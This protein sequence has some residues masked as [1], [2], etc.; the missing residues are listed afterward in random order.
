MNDFTTT[1]VSPSPSSQRSRPGGAI[2]RAACGLGLAA[3]GFFGY[4]LLVDVPWIRS[5]GI[6]NA[7]LLILG[8]VVSWSALWRRPRWAG[9]VAS[10]L[11]TLVTLMFVTFMYV[12]RPPAPPG[13]PSG[14]VTLASLDIPLMD[15]AGAPQKV[16][17][18]SGKGPVL[19][20]FF[21]GHW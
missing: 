3:A 20:T 19:L 8:M 7:M 4:M 5:W 10:V 11:T 9:L 14:K 18:F 12:V 1:S 6:P 16:S 15:A 13:P 21:R 17:D 2:L